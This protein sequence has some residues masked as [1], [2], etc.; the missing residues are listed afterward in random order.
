MRVPRVPTAEVR[1][2]ATG[3]HQ[4]AYPETMVAPR[5]VPTIDAGPMYFVVP[6]EQCHGGRH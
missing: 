5:G 1:I 4:K 3:G 6:F 2:V